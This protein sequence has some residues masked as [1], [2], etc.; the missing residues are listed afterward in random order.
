M[1]AA[2][3]IYPDAEWADRVADRLVA[4]LVPGRR[5]CVPTGATPL[6]V[7]QRVAAERPLDGVILFLLDEF[8]G[9]PRDDPG[10]CAAMLRRDLLDPAGGSPVVHVPDVDA[11][12]PA[13]AAAGFAELIGEGVDLAIVGLG[14]NGH[15]G[16]NEPGSGRD[17]RTRVVELAPS[18]A[19]RA[20]AYGATR[21]PH[22]GIT[23]G[24]AEL[25]RAKEVWVLVTGSH[26]REILD[27]ALHGPVG[28]DVP[29]SF[30]TEH[31]RCVFL[32][33]ESAAITG[34]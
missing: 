27:R 34:S 8:G 29:A 11:D 28:P 1:T 32:V 2:L 21:T 7:Y 31:D 12:D 33:D 9:L 18:T 24:I 25:M 26:K 19:R 4:E 5:V 13:N 17:S 10:R 20:L 30:L 14:T 22:W 6:P 23:V 16:M 15:V 3:E